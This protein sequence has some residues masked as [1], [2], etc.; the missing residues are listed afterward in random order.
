MSTKTPVLDVWVLETK[1]VYRKVPFSVVTDWIQQVRLLAEDRVRPSGTERWLPLA[2]VPALAAY[3]PKV[4]KFRVED[5]AEALEPVRVDFGWRG[6]RGDDDQDVDMIPLIDISLVLLIFFMMTATV[7]GVASL[8]ATPSAEY[9]LMTINSGVWIGMDQ[10]PDGAPRYSM[11]R[12]EGGQA[13]EF[14]N[15]AEL[16]KRLR[17]DLSKS[18][19]VE[20]RVR[21]HKSL[22]YE[23]VTE[24]V[25]ELEKLK[26]AGKIIK[27]MA[28]V[29]DKNS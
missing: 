15:R 20:V 2:E 11:G 23:E 22:P 3:L 1:A 28:E 29:S 6:R 27:I 17:D 14:S 18:E 16:L 9:R 12:G 8:I 7:G 13:D 19:P 5:R 4:E 10:G 26:R 25:S 24:M 21:A